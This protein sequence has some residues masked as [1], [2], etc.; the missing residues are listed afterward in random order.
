MN[1]VLWTTEQGRKKTFLKLL[2]RFLFT[3]KVFLPPSPSPLPPIIINDKHAGG[4]SKEGRK[5]GEK[6]PSKSNEYRRAFCAM[7]FR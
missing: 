1:G 3:V 5:K 7:I 6:G 4:T 2:E